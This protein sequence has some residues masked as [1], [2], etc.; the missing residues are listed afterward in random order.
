MIPDKPTVDVR[1][2]KFGQ[3]VFATR[4]ILRRKIVGEVLGQVI[5]DP[6]YSSDYSMDMG[7]GNQI[8]PAHPFRYMNHSCEPNCELI[9]Y[10]PDSLNDGQEHLL[11]R[12]FVRSFKAIKRGEELLI[13]YAWP[14][15]MSIRCGC[16]AKKC[17]GWI[18]RKDELKKVKK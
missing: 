11:D 5:T 13:D 16:G 4:D 9:Y 2:A 17:R 10:E 18:V 14:A 7:N 12:L 1:K 15:Q 3:G 8:E 6:D